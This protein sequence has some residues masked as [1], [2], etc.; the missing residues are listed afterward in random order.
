MALDTAAWRRETGQ[1]EETPDRPGVPAELLHSDAASQPGLF[2]VLPQ[3]LLHRDEVCLDL[4]DEE[5]SSAFM[6]SEQV[7]RSTFTVD[8]I[9]DLGPD[10]PAAC[11]KK[12][13]RLADQRRVVLIEHSIEVAASPAKLDEEL[14][15]EREGDAPNLVQGDEVQPP[16]L[17]QRDDILRD[18]GT[19][20]EFRLGPASSMPQRSE[21]SADPDLHVAR[22]AST[23]CFPII[24]EAGS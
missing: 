13:S 5:R 3:R 10:I 15:V 24:Y 8:R 6:P 2:V 7:D 4:D 17:D 18:P 19:T 22:M 16:S 14:R 9:R 21:A 23:A 12:L 20:P 11:P 1:D